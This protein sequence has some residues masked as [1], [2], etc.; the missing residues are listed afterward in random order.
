MNP[1]S[2]QV[3]ILIHTVSAVILPVFLFFCPPGI[4]YWIIYKQLKAQNEHVHVSDSIL[5]I[6]AGMAAIVIYLLGLFMLGL[7]V[8]P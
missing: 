1:I 8:S 5:R 2:D 6:H 4:V 3:L 7:M